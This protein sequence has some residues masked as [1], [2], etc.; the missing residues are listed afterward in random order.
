MVN[1]NNINVGNPV[2]FTSNKFN[3]KDGMKE[4]LSTI[5]KF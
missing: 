2:S 4:F 5:T 1:I 3:Y